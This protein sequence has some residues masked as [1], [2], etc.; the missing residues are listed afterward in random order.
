VRVGRPRRFGDVWL[1]LELAKKLGLGALLDRLIPETSADLDTASA[2]R[3]PK[4][5]WARPAEVLIVSRFCEPPSE[6][7]IA[8]AFYRKSALADLMGI[9]E[10]DIYDNRLYRALDKLLEHKDEIQ[11]H[12]KERLGELFAIK[13][14]ILLYDV[15]STYFEGVV[16]KNPQA[17][18][19]YP[20]YSRPDCP[21]VCIGM[22][23]SKEGIPLGYEVFEGNRH[24]S[25]TVETIV[26]KMESLY[27][28]K[29]SCLDHG[30]GHGKRREPRTPCRGTP[31]ISCLHAQES[32]QTV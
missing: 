17:K 26:E 31:P 12:L 15:T 18:R 21:Q 11:Q 25:T 16:A 19:G 10:D 23:V 7:H 13:Y 20:H 3:P 14:D 9:P 24:D 8:K 32:A 22:V 6:L 29:R 5:A 28:K 1:A 2:G 30:P 27:G 4:I